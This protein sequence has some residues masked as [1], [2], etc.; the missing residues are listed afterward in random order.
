M[1]RSVCVHP[2]HREVV[3]QALK[4][5]GFLTQGALAVH[6]EMALSTVNNFCRGVRVSVSK[7]EEIC[8]VL[9]LEASSLTLPVNAEIKAPVANLAGGVEAEATVTFFAYDRAWVGRADLLRS[10]AE[11]LRS[12][13]RLLMIAGIA[14][15]GKT[16]LAERLVIELQ[17]S[18]RLIRSNFDNQEQA[19][20]FGSVAARLLEKCGQRVTPDERQQPKQLG[21]RLFKHLQEHAYLL[22]VDS[23]EALLVGGD[24]GDSAFH[25]QG[26]LTFLQQVL[27][28]DAFRSRIILTTQERPTQIEALGTRSQNV[29]HYHPLTGLSE[30]E[31]RSLFEKMGFEMGDQSRDRPYL[32]RIG[33]AY[34]GHPLALRIIGGEIGSHPFFGNVVAYWHRYGSEIEAVEQA[35]AEAAAGAV[36]GAEDKW[37]LDRF[38]RALR[39]NVRHRLEQTFQRLRRDAENA[40]LLLCEASVYRCPV[41]EDWWLSHLDYLELTTVNQTVIMDA[42]RD[43]YLVDEVLENDQYLLKQHNLIRSIA[44]EHLTNLDNEDSP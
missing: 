24:G 7:F 29:W 13:C 37:A 34:E 25:D 19:T 17:A 41:P 18:P 27:T 11:K 26:Y 5:H 28:A 4:Q 14:G 36:T 10:L 16:A 23:L 9:E 32:L 38:T 20:D 8:D 2:H 6:L 30:T 40:Y 21:W 43:R 22:V 1:S 15:V 31:Q 39:L 42:L 12:D 44:L 33:K 35:I 3:T